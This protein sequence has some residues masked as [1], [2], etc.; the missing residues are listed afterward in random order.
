FLP[1]RYALFPHLDVL[2]N[3]AY[4][5]AGGSRATRRDAALAAL[6]A[7]D[8][9]SLASRRPSELSGGEAQRVALARA[10]AAE[11][12]ALLLDEPLAALDVELR[13][14]L[15]QFLAQYLRALRIPTVVV[16]HDRTDVELLDGQVIVLERGEV[17]QRGRQAELAASPAT[18]FV[19]QFWTV[20]EPR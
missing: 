16:T 10:L 11:P 6:R 13:R 9:T 1:Q 4:G 8:A 17:V 19:R 2:E 18:D 14:D 20:P 3:V 7:L 5:I 12:R 15:R